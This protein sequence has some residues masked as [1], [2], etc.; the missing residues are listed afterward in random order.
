MSLDMPLEL[1]KADNWFHTAAGFP[2]PDWKKIG[3]WVDANVSPAELEEAWQ[4]IALVW[5][6]RVRTRLG[7]PYELCQSPNFVLLSALDPQKRAETLRFLEDTL[8]AVQRVLR[9]IVK[10]E[11]YGKHV[12]IIFQRERLYYE[13]ISYFYPDDGDYAGSSGVFLR[14]GYMHLA[15]PSDD[16]ARAQ[17][18][19]VH[20]LI[21]NCL[22]Q[23][24]LPAWL[25]EGITSLL[26]HDLRG[27]RPFIIDREMAEKHYAFWNTDTIQEFWSG[28]SFERADD[29]NM[30]SYDLAQLLVYRMTHETAGSPDAFR[31]FVRRAEVHDAGKGA[32]KEWLGIELS[33]LLEGFLGPGQWDPSPDQW[34]KKRP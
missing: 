23:L 29:G 31:E 34:D 4:Q 28:K 32:A 8:A 16:L 7:A 2:R 33:R 30:L 1:P 25:N 18:V 6:E 3:K 5:L 13:Y 26:E 27:S 10:E 14:D 9:G 12:A 17:P 21:H 11:G 24:P 15:L 20:E 19:L 22:S